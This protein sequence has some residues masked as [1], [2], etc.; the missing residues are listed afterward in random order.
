MAVGS[1]GPGMH[2]PC[3]GSERRPNVP[4]SQGLTGLRPSGGARLLGARPVLALL[5]PLLRSEMQVCSRSI[6]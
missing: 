2:Q 4:T 5:F 6:L 3:L 1:P